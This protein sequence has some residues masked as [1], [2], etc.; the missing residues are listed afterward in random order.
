MIE[1]NKRD[2]MISVI[3]S[4][5]VNTMIIDLSGTRGYDLR[6][7]DTFVYRIWEATGLAP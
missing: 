2:K 4:E 7:R 6:R 5:I 3:K 1:K